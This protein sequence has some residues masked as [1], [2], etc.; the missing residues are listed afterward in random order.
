[1]QQKI[2]TTGWYEHIRL[3]AGMYLGRIGDGSDPRD[4]V[5]TL[6]KEILNNAI[7][8]FRRGFGNLIE[9]SAGKNSFSVRDYGRGIESDRVAMVLADNYYEAYTPDPQ[10]NGV[11]LTIGIAGF[12]LR[13]NIAL[14][15]YFL[16]NS[17][18]HGRL[19]CLEKTHG[20]FVE[21]RCDVSNEP[22]GTLV[23]VSPDKKIFGTDPI[24]EQFV[25]DIIK[26]AV[27][28]NKGLTIIFNGKKYHS[29]NGLLDLV[30]ERRAEEV[31]YPLIYLEGK[32]IEI[33][34]THTNSGGP[35]ITSFVNGHYTKNGGT[36]QTAVEDAIVAALNELDGKRLKADKSLCG[37][38]GAIS[39]NIVQPVF[40]DAIKSKLVS[41]YM[42]GEDYP[43][44]DSK[45]IRTYV[46][47]FIKMNLPSYLHNTQRPSW[48]FDR[49]GPRLFLL[50]KESKL[51][52]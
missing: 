32:D 2:E 13:I 33:V 43:N 52:T 15:S 22:D 29:E 36:H 23:R 46:M 3:R 35:Y 19:E 6:F 7:D 44:A 40:E 4:G 12:G 1:M 41:T 18:R 28:L 38:T 17:H 50:I 8:E 30:L 27:C 21:S 25:E 31:L 51:A 42:D 39:I 11:P 34:L 16:V 5:Y 24:R 10:S 47:N 37:I 26:M 9:V 14:S 48:H 45:A 49:N 20:G